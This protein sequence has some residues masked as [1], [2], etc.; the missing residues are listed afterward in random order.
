MMLNEMKNSRSSDL[1][2]MFYDC[3]YLFFKN[4]LSEMGTVLTTSV[5]GL[6]ISKLVVNNLNQ[7]LAPLS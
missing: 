6:L 5:K 1:L 3:R 4:D 2:P 7:K